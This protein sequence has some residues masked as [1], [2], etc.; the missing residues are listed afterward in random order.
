MICSKTCGSKVS[1]GS[2]RQM[3]TD[4]TKLKSEHLI[5]L[6]FREIFWHRSYYELPFTFQRKIIGIFLALGYWNKL[7]TCPQN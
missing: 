3:L 5:G 1:S 4:G 6:Q 7:E 2:V